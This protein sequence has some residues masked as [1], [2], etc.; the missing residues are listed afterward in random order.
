MDKEKI[1]QN[2]ERVHAYV[3]GSLGCSFEE[4]VEIFIG[5]IDKRGSIN[6]G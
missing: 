5:V 6:H 2:I 1:E 3:F 4:C